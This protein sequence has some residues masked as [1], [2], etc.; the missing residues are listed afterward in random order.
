LGYIDDQPPPLS[1]LHGHPE[2]LLGGLDDVPRVLSANQVDEVMICLPLRSHYERIEEIANAATEG[3]I[4]VRM[5]ADFFELRLAHA[6]VD[7]L[8]RIPIVT[9]A[10]STPPAQ[11]LLIKRALDILGASAGLLLLAPLLLVIGVAVSLDSP[12]PILFAQERVGLGR[13]RFWMW[14]Y[15]TMLQGSEA[16][17]GVLEARN[18]LRGAAFKLW[19][20]PRVTRVGRILRRLSL[21]ELPQ[22][23]NVLKGEMSLVGPRPLWVRDAERISV[24]WQRRRFSMKPGLT[25]L[26]QANGRHEISFDHWMEL[27]LQYID[28]WSP[29][30]DVEILMKTVPAVI[31]GTG[32]S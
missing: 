25:C 2:K 4:V 31:R 30:L 28:N 1:P 22:L 16:Q 27:D 5:P 13:R 8:H 9:L 20:D 10:A 21:D 7:H 26:W 17:Q 23:F 12:G 3:G 18:G 15:R 29:T 11:G 19:H 6:D 24:D 14:K 32:A